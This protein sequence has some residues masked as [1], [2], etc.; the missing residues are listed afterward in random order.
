[1]K[2]TLRYLCLA[3]TALLATGSFIGVIIG[4]TATYA[5]LSGIGCN[6]YDA[7]LYGINCRSFFGAKIIE[8]LVG[9]P[10][11]LD[12]LSAISL[13]SPFVAVLALPFWLLVGVV[14]YMAFK[15]LTIRSK[16]RASSN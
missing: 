7:L 13:S 2:K 12:Q 5:D 3:Y 14:V 1:M 8:W 10:L 6:F 11:L 16:G 9:F 15:R 4:Y